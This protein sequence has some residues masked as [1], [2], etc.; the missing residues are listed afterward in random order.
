M[1]HLLN[2]RKTVGCRLLSVIAAGAAVFLLPACEKVI[3]VDLNES[4][5]AV[6]IEGNLSWKHTSLKVNISTTGSYFDSTGAGAVEGAMVYLE[7]HDG[8][9]MHV[10]DEGKGV[11]RLDK[12][13]L[14]AGTPYTLTAEVNGQQY[15]AASVLNPPVKIDSLGC[16]YFKEARFYDG[17]YRMQLY[18][19]DPAGQE[20]YYRVKV[21]K[22]GVLFNSASDLI[23]FDDGILDGKMVQ[24]RL[25]GQTF[26]AGDTARVEL[27]SIDK[28]A[29]EYF[30]TLREMASLNPGSPAPANPV[31]NFSNGA[32]GYF[33]AWSHSSKVA[34]I[35][36]K[37]PVAAKNEDLVVIDFN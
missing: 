7:T 34:F 24:V 37:M 8:N 21:Y 23:V 19:Q 22:N 9:R 33:S 17:G 36:N 18:F 11:Y 16:E 3:S 20:N 32:L 25:R 12:V 28:N 26:S 6:V 10:K 14:K 27:L 35:F 1:N 15:T 30:S 5:P 4:E 29:W 31:S 2:F 13:P